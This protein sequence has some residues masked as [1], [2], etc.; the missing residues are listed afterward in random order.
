MKNIRYITC[1]DLRED[2][3]PE[4]A[5]ELLKIS[6]KVELGI[7]AHPGA[8]NFG[9]PRMK[10]L[11]ELLTISQKL[12]KPLNIA[13]HVNYDWCSD[14]CRGILAGE[15][16]YLFFSENKDTGEPLIKRWQLNI[17]DK[18]RGFDANKLSQITLNNPDREFIFPYNP[19]VAE[20]IS[21]LDKTGAA[22]SLL[23]DQS[24]GFGITPQ[25]WLPPV[26]SNHPQG[27]AGGLYGD[28]ISLNLDKIAKL[29]PEDYEIWID[30]EGKLMIPGAFPR[31]FDLDRGKD[32]ILQ[33]LKWLENNKIR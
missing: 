33:T 13:I 30:A 1:S 25:Q 32:Y 15:L 16:R 18:T 22:F 23:F 10:W 8:M 24:Y 21:S 5:I 28:N 6:D 9:T 29:V 17:G 12:F 20:L 26:Y 19:G 31:Q 14:F 27:Y 2:I 7:Q 3:P 4:K 11:V